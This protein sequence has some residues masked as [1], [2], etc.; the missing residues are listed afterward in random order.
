MRTPE[1]FAGAEAVAE[2]NGE[3]ITTDEIAKL[4]STPLS[5]LEEQIYTLKRRA[6]DALIAD[7]LVVKE[8]ARRQMSVQAL[9]EAETRDVATVT[10]QEIEATYR[11]QKPQLGTD[12][13]AAKERI[14][15]QLRALKIA[16][17]QRAFVDQL[18]EQ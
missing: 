11:Q 3:A 6:L 1:V 12:E 4:V 15:E 18:R 14:R 8:A 17:R 2:V 7:R 9:L 5:K 10:E 16:A 13:A